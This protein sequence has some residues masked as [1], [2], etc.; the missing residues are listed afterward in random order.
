MIRLFILSLLIITGVLW[1]TLYIGFPSDPGYFLF[2]F[3]NYTFETSLLALSIIVFLIFLL[4]R[5]L[6]RVFRWISPRRFLLITQSIN[7][8]MKTSVRSHTKEGL[9][10]FAR[11][12]W[13][14]SYSLLTKSVNDEDASVVNFL[15]AAYAAHKAGKKDAW[16]NCLENAE[17]KYPAS[18][19]T[20]NLVKAKLF[21]DSGRL[22]EA[23]LIL[24]KIQKNLLNDAIFLELSKEVYVKLEA[25]KTLKDLIPK[26]EKH[27]VIN[28]DEI[29]KIRLRIFMEELYASWRDG[30]SENEKGIHPGLKK[31]WKKAP[32]KFRSNE[33]VVYHYADLLIRSGAKADA[34]RALETAISK[35]WSDFL[36]SYYSKQDFNTGPRQLLTAEKWLKK[37]PADATLLLVL[38]RISMRNK[39]WEKARDY[40]EHSIKISPSAEAYVELSRLLKYLDEIEASE[41][42]LRNY[43]NFIGAQLPDLPLPGEN[44]ITH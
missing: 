41:L 9:L 23:A 21:H 20:I 2:V 44:E 7:D 40:Y 17:A 4:I 16:L 10:Y 29:E 8:R 22:E 6:I 18:G 15:A 37:R 27:K 30:I 35:V 43:F 25:W 14:S 1:L 32:L 11:G 42:C 38:G 26:L 5:L 39:L 24:K 12:N 31:L 36:V 34:A 3:G 33:K 28:S 19:S 13:R